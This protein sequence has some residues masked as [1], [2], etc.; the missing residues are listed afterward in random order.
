VN[1]RKADEMQHPRRL[2]NFRK[3]VFFSTKYN[4]KYRNKTKTQQKKQTSKHTV[5]LTPETTLL[6][7]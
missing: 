5:K 1:V 4:N 6:L 2:H 3:L 7:D